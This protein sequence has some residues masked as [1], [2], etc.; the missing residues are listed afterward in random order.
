MTTYDE[1]RNEIKQEILRRIDDMDTFTFN[2]L[3]NGL[4]D[5]S[6]RIA[7]RVLQTLRKQ[8]KIDYYKSARQYIWYKVKS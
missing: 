6:Y 3:H 2:Q 5:K 1:R 8:G 4:G 7:D